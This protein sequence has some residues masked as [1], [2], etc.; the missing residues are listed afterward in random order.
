MRVRP[1]PGFVVRDPE[2]KQ[3][4]PAEGREVPAST[5]W[6]RRVKDGDLE[7]VADDDDQHRAGDPVEDLK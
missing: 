6:M 1:R 4:V 5:Y 2:T 3:P 7:L